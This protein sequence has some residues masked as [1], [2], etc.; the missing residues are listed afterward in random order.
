[1]NKATLAAMC[2]LALVELNGKI[3]IVDGSY[4]EP[5]PNRA[6]TFSS[7]LKEAQDSGDAFHMAAALLDYLDAALLDY[8]DSLV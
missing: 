3:D 5:T 8:L 2:N 1:M 6:M 4:G 7:R